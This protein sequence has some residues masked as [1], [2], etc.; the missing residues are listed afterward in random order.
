MCTNNDKTAVEALIGDVINTLRP[1]IRDFL[2]KPRLPTWLPPAK[3]VDG[4]T[5]RFYG[6]LK[7]P[8]VNGK[9]SILLHDLCRPANSN[10]DNLFQAQKHR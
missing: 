5:L 6:S 10:A 9:P 8:L 1:K 3:S 7:V 2:T 4:E